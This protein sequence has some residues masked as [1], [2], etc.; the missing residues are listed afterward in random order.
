MGKGFSRMAG[1]KRMAARHFGQSEAPPV[2]VA[3]VVVVET[4]QQ[5]RY[6]AAQEAKGV[7]LVH[8]AQVDAA[9]GHIDGVTL[10]RKRP[11]A[12]VAAE[13]WDEVTG[14]RGVVLANG[15]PVPVKR[16]KP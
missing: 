2:P 10:V 11:A 7:L 9:D 5:R 13:V 15:K 12:E 1:A 6:K 8:P 14:G 16:G 3:A 4:R